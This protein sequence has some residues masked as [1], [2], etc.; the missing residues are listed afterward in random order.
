LFGSY[1]GRAGASGAGE[2]KT[3]GAFALPFNSRIF[4]ELGYNSCDPSLIVADL[5]TETATLA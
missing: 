2:R 3:H 1:P 4:E 5:L